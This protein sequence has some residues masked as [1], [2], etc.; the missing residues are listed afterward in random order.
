MF[1]FHPYCN[2]ERDGQRDQQRRDNQKPPLKPVGKEDVLAQ[3]EAQQDKEQPT[4]GGRNG[5][6][7]GDFFQISVFF[8]VTKPLKR[9]F[10]VAEK[11][12]LRNGD[13]MHAIDSETV[14][15]TR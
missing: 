14:G 2:P 15:H 9:P 7:G 12:G 13:F 10:P 3:E 5:N 1:A 4:D 6:D 11:D 8:V